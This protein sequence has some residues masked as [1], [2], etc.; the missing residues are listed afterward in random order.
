MRMRPVCGDL[1]RRLFLRRRLVDAQARSST[2]KSRSFMVPR[3]AGGA[4][5][6]MLS[7]S[8]WLRLRGA[9]FSSQ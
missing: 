7:S 4:L 9:R 5:R 6:M 3:R 8:F 2:P 1:E